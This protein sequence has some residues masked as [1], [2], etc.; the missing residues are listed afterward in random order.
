MDH[1]EEEDETTNNFVKID[2]MIQRQYLTK[3]PVPEEGDGV[4]Q[5][6]DDDDDG[7]GQDVLTSSSGEH[8]EEVWSEATEHGHVAEVDKPLNND[9]EDHESQTSK[10]EDHGFIILIVV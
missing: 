2:M 6:A 8:V 5:H 3:T 9:D 1:S 7:Q 4:P 10:C